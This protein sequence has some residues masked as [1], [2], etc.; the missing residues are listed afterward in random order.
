VHGTGVLLRGLRTGQ[1]AAAIITGRRVLMRGWFWLKI[2]LWL[3]LEFVLAVFTAEIVG[4]ALVLG[5]VGRVGRNLHATHRVGVGLCALRF[6]VLGHT[7]PH[8][9]VADMPI[10]TL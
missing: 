10:K 1:F 5:L 3:L 2:L 7:A 8:K 4:L 6:C 9:R